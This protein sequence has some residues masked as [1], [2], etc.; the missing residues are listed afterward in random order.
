MITFESPIVLRSPERPKI[1][2]F[3]KIESLVDLWKC[4]VSLKFID[5]GSRHHDIDPTSPESSSARGLKAS[6][7]MR[8]P[9]R[10]H[11]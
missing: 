6:L 8:V 11:E 10:Q 2:V 7:L 3:S 5:H 1:L 9:P 4:L